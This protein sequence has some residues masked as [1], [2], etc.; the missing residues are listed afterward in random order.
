V[1]VQNNDQEIH[2]NWNPLDSTNFGAYLLEKRAGR[3]GNQWLAMAS[4][5]NHTDTGYTDKAVWV[6]DSSYCYRMAVSNKCGAIGSYGKEACSILL[7]GVVYTYDYH[8]LNWIPYTYFI[9]G[10]NRFEL[11]KTEPGIY[12]DSLLA[13]KTNW[14]YQHQDR[15]LNTDN[16]LYQYQVAA[17][18]K[19]FG[20]GY[21]SWSNQI[22][23]IEPPSLFVP[24][25]ITANGDQLNDVIKTLHV[26]IK[27][28]QFRLYNRWGEMVWESTNKYETLPASFLN[29]PLANDVYFYEVN[30]TGWDNQSYTKKGNISILR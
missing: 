1:T 22:E 28:Y 14:T 3:T 29:K 8:D 19:G 20:Q 9:T 27:T 6:D 10:T 18:E 25:A 26:Y 15:Q 21:S 4:I 2:L 24:N 13:I 7:K 17:F 30:Y 11:Y 12:S 23:L 16:G 5:N